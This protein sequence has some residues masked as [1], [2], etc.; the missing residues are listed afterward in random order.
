MDQKK[1]G[2]LIRRLRLEQG[3]T[4]NRLAQ[5]LGVSG[6]AVSKWERG[7]GCPELSLLPGLARIFQVDLEGLLA[8][9]LEFNEP[10]G[11]NMKRLTFYVCPDCGNLLTAAGEAGITCCGKKL[12]P[13][14]P[15]EPQESQALTVEKVDGEWYVASDHPMEKEHYISFVALAEGDTLVLCRQYPEWNLQARRPASGGA[16]CCGIAPSTGCSA[17]SCNFLTEASAYAVL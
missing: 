4:Q 13:L 11:G 6:Q 8:G 3:M 17:K 9:E 2:E 12:E 15:Q 7:L 10:I 14:T 1:T 16:R 5:R